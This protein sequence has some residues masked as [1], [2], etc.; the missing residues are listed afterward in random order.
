MKPRGRMPTRVGAFTRLAM[1]ERSA[2]YNRR[3]AYA[4]LPCPMMTETSSL[5]E[6]ADGALAS[7]TVAELLRLLVLNEDCIPRNLIDECARRGD[8]MIDAL[9]E[10]LDKA[11]YWGD[12]QSDGEWWLLHHA[13]M[14]LGLI[15]GERA[16]RVLIDFMRRIADV[17]DY[18]LQDW[19]AGY[20]PAL[21][22]NKPAAIVEQLRALAEDRTG[23]VLLRM[24]AATCVIATAS[25]DGPWPLDHALDW[26]GSIAFNADDDLDVRLL[27]A[28]T[29]LDFARPEDRHKLESLGDTQPPTSRV[30]GRDDITRIYAAGG[31]APEWECEPFGDPWRFYTPQAYEQRERERMEDALPLEED[32]FIYADTY[33][34]PTPKIGRNEPCPCG[35][36]KKCKKCCL[37]KDG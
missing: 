29:L 28:N 2:F 35:S 7:H 21:Y 31:E 24:Q 11:Y 32:P 15:P 27:V 4:D 12:D 3:P 20:W 6:Y 36:G 19:L 16:G 8:E 37:A 5:V 34:R 26:A 22:R 17:D 33:V 30:F 13:G 18:A 1:N 14:I 10:L 23:D 25:P 9:S